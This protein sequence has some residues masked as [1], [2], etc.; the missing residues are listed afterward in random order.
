MAIRFE[1]IVPTI[2]IFSVEKAREFYLDYLGFK[3]DWE[4]RFD[5]NAPLLMQVSRDGIL[6]RLSE[7]Y[8]DGSPGTH[9]T[10]EMTGIDQLHA[11]LTA[12]NYRYFRPAVEDQPWNARVMVVYDPFGNK[13]FFSERKP[14][15]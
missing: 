14:A 5:R 13:I 11:E 1:S 8:G 12:K 10:I 7:H 2:R 6:L 4:H 3:L 9:V 15:H